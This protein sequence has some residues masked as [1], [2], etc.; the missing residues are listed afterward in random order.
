MFA[1]RL[2]LGLRFGL[3]RFGDLL[4]VV[5]WCGLAQHTGLPSLRF[6]DLG[7]VGLCG[8]AFGRFW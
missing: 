7:G 6:S 4:C 2:V 1:G 8:F 3:V 5:F